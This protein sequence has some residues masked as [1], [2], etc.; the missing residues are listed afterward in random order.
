MSKNIKEI[1]YLAGVVV[2]NSR[3]LKLVKENYP[4]IYCHHM[5]IKYGNISEL[6][7]F[8]GKEFNFIANK[9][10]KNDQA[11]AITGTLNNSDI[12]KMMNENN[13]H[14]HVTICTAVNV[15][16][17]YS[18]TLIQEAK[19]KRIKRHVKMKVGAFCS[20]DDGT[21]DWVFRK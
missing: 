9:I 20:F 15:K 1:I 7:D 16:P 3:L 17:V 18:N 14:A 11:I 5:T 4:N 6:P 8:I 13:Q 19:G 10:Y 21:T 2:N 12:Q